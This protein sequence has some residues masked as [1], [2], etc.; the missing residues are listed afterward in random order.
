MSPGPSSVRTMLL[1]DTGP[2]VAYLN[3]ND[4]DHDRCAELL[5]GRADELLVTPYVVTEACYLVAKYVG[6]DAE[7]NL[8]EAVAT[9]DLTQVQ[10]DSADLARMAELMR[11]Y[12]AF[13]LG[14]AD[15]SVIAVAERRKLT[16]IAT[17][18]R[19]HFAAVAPLHAPAFDLLPRP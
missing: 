18:D 16:E 11:Q 12:R 6:A 8:V 17:L 4:R 5:E 14:V 9:A 10:V 2:L 1:V 19:R 3:R 13:P 7:I 15:A